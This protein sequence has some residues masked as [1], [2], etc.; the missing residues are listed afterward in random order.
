MCLPFCLFETLRG[1]PVG[2]DGQYKQY[3]GVAL[4]RLFLRPLCPGTWQLGCPALA[5]ILI[6]TLVTHMQRQESRPALT[7]MNRRIFSNLRSS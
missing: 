6:K 2:A 4:E 3:N 7:T 5:R 1:A